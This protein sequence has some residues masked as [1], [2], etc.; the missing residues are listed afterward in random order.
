MNKTVR[1]VVLTLALLNVVVHLAFFDQLGY[2]RDE[3][4]YFS[5]GLHPALGYAT[6]PPLIGWLAMVLQESIGFSLFAVKLTP[7]LLGGVFTWLVALT[8]KELGGRSYAQILAAV[9]VSFAPIFL[10][11]WSLFQPVPLD[12]VL[13]GIA[14]YF[15]LK[16][17]NTETDKWLYALGVTVGLALLNKYLI[18]LFVLALLVAVPFTK[19]R[20]L[21]RDRAFY[22]TT[23]IAFVI[24]LPNLA[25]QWS[26]AFPVFGHMSEL[27]ET[28]LQHLSRAGFLLDQLLLFQSGFIVA[29][30]GLYYL[31]WKRS[32]PRSKGQPSPT[33]PTPTQPAATEPS[34]GVV[35]AAVVIVFVAL[36]VLN[37]KSYYTAGLY[38]I[39]IAAG[40][41]MI[42]SMVAGG[43]ARAVILSSVVLLGIP[44]LPYGLPVL[45]AEK[46]VAYFDRV[47]ALGFDVG[48]TFDDGTR[49]ALPQ[50]YADMLGWDE[51]ANL[52]RLAYASVEDKEATMIFCENYGLAGAV[53]V[54]G[55][56]YDLPEC[57]SFSDSFAYWVPDSFDP[58]IRN[59]IYVNDNLGGDIED[60]F[61]DIV[62]VGRV[63][64]PLAR[65][66]QTQVYLCRQP[67]RPF[68]DFWGEVL[69]GLARSR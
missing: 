38:P 12:I 46:L 57:L 39:L 61:E 19:Y 49:H 7:A 11:A 22:L 8:A 60:L 29:M 42:E 23:G 16:Y 53:S 51:I 52:V 2:H 65:E 6:V 24:V 3:L 62:E 36:F 55:K 48:R 44:V 41:V 50:D 10:R 17:L 26:H 21:F 40:A 28:Q 9:C 58:D 45:P 37:G 66:Y 47:E 68:N 18:G 15:L 33:Q 69:S 32:G 1:T 14:F 30:F 59:F 25:W 34:Y 35:G 27:N 31:L 63:E 67:R 43:Y 56:R 5:L 54:I 64:N 13:W 20:R 4:L